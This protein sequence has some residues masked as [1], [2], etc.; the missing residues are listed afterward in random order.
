MRVTDRLL[1]FASVFP[2]TMETYAERC[3][4]SIP[5]RHMESVMKWLSI[6]SDADVLLRNMFD[7]VEPIA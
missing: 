1:E 5:P 6:R 4:K 7:E 3:S 2:Y